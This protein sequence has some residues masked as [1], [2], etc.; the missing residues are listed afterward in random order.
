M[1]IKEL[2][3]FRITNAINF[4]DNLNP[5]IFI[6]EQMRPV[7][8]RKLMQIA[9]HFREFLGVQDIALVDIQ[10]SGSNAA[11]SY[12]PHSDIDLH[13]L[14]DFTQLPDTDIYREL[15]DAKKYQYNEQHDIKIKGYEVELYVQ[16]AAQTHHSLGTYS[17]LNNEW[18]RFPTKVRANIDEVATKF[19]YNKLKNL[20]IRALASDSEIYI[21]DVLD[22][23]KRYRRAGLSQNGEFGPENL[24]FKLLRKAGYFQK[25][26]T[27]KRE[28][29]DDE[30]SLEQLQNEPDTDL[31]KELQ[32][33][34]ETI[35][36]DDSY[37]PPEIEVGDE[38]KVGK[39]KN[40]KATVKGFEKDKNNQPVLK[41]TKGDHKLFKPRISKLEE[42]GRIV[43]GVNTT[44]DVD[45]DEIRVQA[46]KLGFDVTIGGVPP[47]LREA[48]FIDVW[49]MQEEELRQDLA[50][51]PHIFENRDDYKNI[52][53]FLQQYKNK[54]TIGEKYIFTS[55]FLLIPGNSLSVNSFNTPLELVKLE[56]GY[57]YFQSDS[58]IKKYPEGESEQTDLL[59]S[60]LFFKN[61]NSLNKFKTALK[62][63]F[64]TL[65]IR[66]GQISESGLFE[67]IQ[68]NEVDMSPGG[69]QKQVNKL[70][71]SANPQIGLEFEVIM[72]KDEDSN[73]DITKHTDLSDIKEFF[74]HN[75][76]EDFE[77]IANLYMEWQHEKELEWTTDQVDAVLN[78]PSDSS[79]EKV[80][81]MVD[82]HSTSGEADE[83][84][85]KITDDE[86]NSEITKEI[87]EKAIE[88]GDNAFKSYGPADSWP[89]QSTSNLY[90]QLYYD[91]FHENN[92]EAKEMFSEKY[93]EHF[94]S[95]EAYDSEYSLGRWLQKN[96]INSMGDIWREWGEDE[97]LH[98]TGG[99]FSEEDYDELVGD[100]IAN[101][102]NQLG[103][104]LNVENIGDEHSM[105]DGTFWAI[106]SDSSISPDGDYDAGL[107]IIMPT[108]DYVEG[109]EDI[110]LV[111][112]YLRKNNAYTNDSTGL[113]INVSLGNI[114]HSKLDYAKLIIMLGDSYILKQFGRDFNEFAR[115]SLVK[116]GELLDPT[117]GFERE[118]T[119]KAKAYAALMG[120]MRKNLNNTI[121]KEFGDI[122]F[123]NYFGKG[124]SINFRHDYVEFRSPGGRNYLDNIDDII[125]TI[126]RFVVAYAI[127]AD[128][129]S[130]KK[131]YGKKLYKLASNVSSGQAS[132]DTMTL[133]AAFG[134]KIIDKDELKR[135]LKEKA[136]KKKADKE[137]VDKGEP[138][139]PKD[140]Q[141]MIQII[142]DYYGINDRS[143]TLRFMA[144]MTYVK[145]EYPNIS[146]ERME[147]AVFDNLMKNMDYYD[148]I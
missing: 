58:G 20:A 17:V 138:E 82:T 79:R 13:L 107:E 135:K 59:K 64:G 118:K 6:D 108:M 23:V 30:L 53:Q 24:A 28:Y 95:S 85:V 114:D 116:L 2:D 65:T 140:R 31:E 63:K 119:T 91:I 35:L 21:T 97:G 25:L 144:G 12:T 83:I 4:N 7:V 132:K 62:L 55:I 128:P 34:F 27:K 121:A 76:D 50:T 84:I 18:V 86:D 48:E 113:H 15:F 92:E 109:I 9:D 77:T 146:I 104:E 98:W 137:K 75:S 73:P 120:N 43:K 78:N 51:K 74:E 142:A 96:H 87:A 143:V 5:Q 136:A 93:S 139:K 133:F 46:K 131:E 57:A 115:N 80:E 39:F 52:K 54:P 61:T 71:Q 88:I 126:N 19:K 67:G 36:D 14:V 69:L 38:V 33:E 117:Q 122:N 110:R 129:E 16:D 32:M 47:L 37:Q 1:H 72:R 145:N 127:A 42:E 8:H 44:Q 100:N 81:F 102:L 112:D 66:F 68:L 130:H 106:A 60:T 41:T 90:L 3:N 11:Y 148:E 99:A 49:A 101:D 123:D 22:I 105:A 147:K 29:T 124:T 103:L 26:W 56:D 141:D 10:V 40:R 94:W 125:N 134:A 89:I 111:V 45:V 70:V